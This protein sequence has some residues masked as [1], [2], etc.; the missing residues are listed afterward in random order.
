[1]RSSQ[2]FSIRQGT[3]NSL[4]KKYKKT[5]TRT[6]YG[7]GISP[8]ELLHFLPLGKWRKDEIQESGFL[9]C[10]L[11]G[12]LDLSESWFQGSCLALYDIM[13]KQTKYIDL[14]PV[15]SFTCSA[16]VKRLRGFSP[17]SL[18]SW[19]VQSY[20]NLDTVAIRYSRTWIKSTFD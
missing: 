16:V 1:M 8:W 6:R 11:K 14:K 9:S 5:T 12:T 19:Q 17:C 15:W 18:S 7:I 10:H 13:Q 2:P 20:R 4:S 3:F